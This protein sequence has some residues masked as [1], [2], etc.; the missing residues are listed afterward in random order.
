[1]TSQC[2]QYPEYRISDFIVLSG[3]LVGREHAQRGADGVGDRGV[4][5]LG[6]I[7]GALLPFE[8]M[9]PLKL[10]ELTQYS[11]LG[12]D[13]SRFGT[14]VFLF[15]MNQDR[16]DELPDD[17]KAI[18]DRNTGAAIAE[19]AGSLWDEIEKPGME[20]QIESGGEIVGIDAASKAKFDALSAKI[21]ERWVEEIN[22][23]G[24][25]GGALVE[26]AKASVEK[27]SQ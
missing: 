16:Y 22:D 1:M 15:L 20:M 10:H 27:R 14:S 4:F 8:I 13:G 23:Q 19:M 12:E 25:D 9:P 26:S 2:Q 3:G 5:F 11:I 6:A 18:I 24:L 21:E 17:L 7:D